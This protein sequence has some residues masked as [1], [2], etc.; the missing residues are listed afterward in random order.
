MTYFMAGTQLARVERLMREGG[1][2]C[3]V[4]RLQD[5]AVAGFFLT[6]NPRRAADT[7]EG[8]LEILKER[9]PEKKIVRR[10]E[11]MITAVNS[12]HGVYRNA[13][14]CIRDRVCIVSIAVSSIIRMPG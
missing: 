11:E 4:N 3:P 13:K 10:V 2:C 7:Y 14:M 6:R 9:I 8:Q 12:R 5:Q 1:N